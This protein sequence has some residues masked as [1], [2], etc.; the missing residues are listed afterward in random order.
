MLMDQRQRL[1]DLRIDQR[2]EPAG[3]T[4]ARLHE[5]RAHGLDEQDVSEAADDCFRARLSCRHFGSDELERGF[6]PFDRRAA[7][8]LNV[9][10]WGQRPNQ[11]ITS[12]VINTKAAADE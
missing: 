9:N 5:M 3:R 4:L 8:A 11:R 12:G 10:D 7:V 6:E 1:T 2:A